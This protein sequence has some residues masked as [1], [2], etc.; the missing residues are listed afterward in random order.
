MEVAEKGWKALAT[1]MG[2][3]EVSV[4]KRRLALLEAGV[5]FYSHV[6]RPPRRM[7]H[8]FPSQIIRFTMA[9][10]GKF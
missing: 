8:F 9:N 5:I 6:G 7:V 10:E 2:K 1:M 3:S 4:K